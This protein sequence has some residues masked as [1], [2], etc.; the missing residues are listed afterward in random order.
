MLEMFALSTGLRVN[1]AK[2]G[3]VPL[4]MTDEKAKLMTGVF[5]CSLREMPFTYL[6]LPMGTFRPKVE[7]YAPLMNR[8]ERLLTSISML[9]HAGRLQRVNSVFSASPT[10]TMCS[11]TVPITI[12]EYFDRARRHCMWR[13]SE[14]NGKNKPLVA[15]KKMYKGKKKRRSGNNQP[16]SAE[17]GT[18]SKTSGQ[19]LQQG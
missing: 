7:H 2:S 15:W 10:Y 1:Y 12:Y 8:M 13:N 6:G 3:M 4:N 11:L 5:G 18:P 19:I 16:E 17:Q 14:S 9:N